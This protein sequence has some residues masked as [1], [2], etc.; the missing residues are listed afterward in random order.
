MDPFLMELRYST[1]LSAKFGES[2]LKNI[3]QK[4]GGLIYAR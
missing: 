3:A 2:C 1:I 4:H